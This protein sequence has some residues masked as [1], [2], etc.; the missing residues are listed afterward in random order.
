MMQLPPELLG[1]FYLGAEHDL[2]SG[3]SS[4]TAINYD[5]RDLTTHAVCVGMTGSGKTGL[6]VSLLEE[7]ALDKLPAIVIDPKGDV[8]NLMLQFP[9]L[10]AQD[11]QPWID[12]DEARR[13]GQPLE[14]YAQ[15][16]AQAWQAGLAEWGMGPERIRALSESADFNIYTPGSDSGL[17]VSI[18]GSLAAPALDFERHA[19]SI[20]ER[21]SGT[22][23]ALLGM[24]GIEADPI[25]SREAI[26][27]SNIM[28]HFWRRDQDVD[29]TR[30]ITSIQNPP[31]R[32]MGV[33][34]VDVFYPQQERFQLAMTFN[35]LV[36]A[37][38]FQGWLAG[39]AL[40]V[41]KLL[42]TSTGQ[43]RH[44]IF[45]LA[46]LS[47]SERM[48]FVTLLLEN[49]L[50]WMRRQTGTTSLRALLYFDEIFGFFPPVAEPP[51]KRPLLTLLK[52][53]RAVGLG[54]VLVSQNPIDI[55]YKG[56][57]NAG[58]WFIGKL[59]TERDKERVLQG[60]QGAIS[61]AG[62]DAG[63]V[64]YKSLIGRLG[65]RLFLMHNVHRD[66]PLVFQTRH[67]LS[68]LRGPLTKPQV[69]QL[70]E[71]KKKV[72][73]PR[74]KVTGLR[75]QTA[76]SESQGAEP[77]SQVS[78]LRSQSAESQSSAFVSQG[79][80]PPLQPETSN[81]EPYSPVPPALDPGVTQVYAPVS[82]SQQEAVR[83]LNAD[84]GRALVV[85]DVRLAYDPGIVGG[86]IVRFADRKQ[87]INTQVEHVLLAPAP[88]VTGGTSWEA[89]EA[90]PM[91]LSDLSG[92]AER[93][94]LEQEPLFAPAPAGADSAREIA[95]LARALQ[96]WLYHN[97]RLTLAAHPE[98]GLVQ[99]PNETEREFKIRVQQ[100][101]R[102]RRDA[103]VDALERKHA[104]SI[105]KL[106]AK[107]RKH[108]RNLFAIE[109][110]HRARKQES[111]IV[112][113]ESV[114]NF[115]VGRRSHT[116]AISV[117]ARKQRLAGQ[118]E[119]EV[120]ETEQEIA[121]LE[122]EIRTLQSELQ[123]TTE[124]ITHKWDAA[125]DDL[126]T[127]E[128]LP[129]RADVDVRLTALAWLPS[130]LIRYRLRAGGAQARSH[131]A[132]VAA[133]PLPEQV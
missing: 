16:A 110:E 33:F 59:Q 7:A 28:E 64:D 126:T 125:L 105:K 97:S 119:I 130:W 124:E 71:A 44:S 56:L 60:L 74:S 6:C 25:R 34:D 83:Q 129:K 35:N 73:G 63:R 80:E 36:A 8:S 94:G 42:Y 122:K 128:F 93:A 55:D 10:E 111:T 95:S 2:D 3:Q 96:D 53:A 1:S 81:L 38:A 77:K 84:V 120:E 12:P 99:V 19:E 49:V 115:F 85:E 5:A 58:T 92:Q 67:A 70:M 121:D 50:T 24:V 109:A 78:G 107:L 102:E 46:H 114:L 108:E 39:D 88:E 9:K 116:R 89:A 45:Y 61:K 51:S 72:A 21:I 104:A 98:L 15:T 26:L 27:L 48:F 131:T 32:Q 69:Q 82:V 18:L 101:A 118:A 31:V 86:A 103:E 11:L 4:Q 47:D 23:V 106:E 113:G 40:D 13:A 133:Y 65:S 14:D 87:G 123:E 37:P 100:A 41:D 79:A 76:D 22:V 62:G 66:L 132:S 52:Q 29:L 75:S 30:L 54:C 112:L 57:S 91:H 90:L 68:Y 127:Q 17:P 43:P 20:R 117:I